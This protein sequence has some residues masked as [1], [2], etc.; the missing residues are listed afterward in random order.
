MRYG[1]MVASMMVRIHRGRRKD[2]VSMSGLMVL[3]TK[4]TG[5]TTRLMEQGL[6]IGLMDG[7]LLENGKIIRCMVKEYI[8]GQMEGLT[9]VNTKMI[10]KKDSESISGKMG[11]Y[12]KG[13]GTMESSMVKAI[14]QE[15]MDRSSLVNG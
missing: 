1:L 15:A 13:N 10:R 4:E 2:M 12:T 6:T 9:R 3:S 7:L 8:L 5:W 11:E 14:I